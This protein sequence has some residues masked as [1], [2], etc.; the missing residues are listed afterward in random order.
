MSA[1][2]KADGYVLSSDERVRCIEYLQHGYAPQPIYATLWRGGAPPLTFQEFLRQFADAVV[3]ATAPT[4][5][6]YRVALAPELRRR[7]A[8]LDQTA[9]E[10]RAALATLAEAPLP[11]EDEKREAQAERQC[12]VVSHYG[13]AFQ[14][15]AALAGITRELR[16]LRAGQLDAA[17]AIVGMLASTAGAKRAH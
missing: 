7:Q 12:A 17:A 8:E 13:K 10:L 3:E 9:R 15:V 14:I 2:V 1:I 5:E 6:H 16:A 11:E 4:V